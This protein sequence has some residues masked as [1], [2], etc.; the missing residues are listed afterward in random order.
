MPSSEEFFSKAKSLIPGGVNSPVRAFNAVGGEP[1]FFEKAKGS[2]IFSVEGDRYTDFILSWGP[3]ILGHSH[4][5]V[6]EAM[7]RQIQQGI[8]LGMPSSYE[9][10][11][12]EF[13]CQKVDIDMVRFVNS[14]TEATMSA[15]RLARGVTKKDNIIKFEGCYHGHSDGLLVK[16]G[17]G[18]ATFGISDS[19]GVPQNYAKNTIVLP[20]NDVDMLEKTFAQNDIA[21]VILEPICGNMGVIEARQDFLQTLR[22][23]CDRHNAILIFDE[24]M[25]ALRV[26]ETTSSRLSN[27]EADLYCLGKIIGGGM[28]VGAFGG[29]KEIMNCLAPNGGVYQAGTLSGNP[30]AMVTGY[31]TL[32]FYYENN[33]FE[34]VD[35]LGKYLEDCVQGICQKFNDLKFKRVGSMFTLFFNSKSEDIENFTDVGQSDFEK[36]K[37]FFNFALQKKILLPPSQ[38]EATF[39]SSAHTEKQIDEYCQVLENF[40]KKGN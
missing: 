10:E 18:G 26:S 39:L 21:G 40:L 5:Q 29:K 24:V 11:F 36:F 31:E 14:G 35:T 4:P 20:Y 32:K 6:V 12:A 2:E 30:L 1:I 33:I 38:Y 19:L 3:A 17:S 23:L 9:V 27:V 8:S 25:C 37:Q 15:I 7:Q 34:K 13:V 16:A 28:P 22:R